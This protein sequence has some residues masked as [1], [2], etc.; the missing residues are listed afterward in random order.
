M[1][2]E[3]AIFQLLFYEKLFKI[4]D[5]NKQLL[6]ICKYKKWQHTIALHLGHL[7]NVA[8]RQW[9]YVRVLVTNDVNIFSVS[10]FML[11]FYS[12]LAFAIFKSWT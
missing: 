5:S 7:E 3:F 12:Y 4:A 2:S 10:L 8:Q 1:S 6:P 9:F 11:L